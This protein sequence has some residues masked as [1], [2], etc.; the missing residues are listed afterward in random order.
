MPE[1]V[2]TLLYS[3]DSQSSGVKFSRNFFSVRSVTVTVC[4]CVL[5]ALFACTRCDA[6]DDDDAWL[7]GWLHLLG[8]VIGECKAPIT[9]SVMGVSQSRHLSPLLLRAIAC[10]SV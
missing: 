2:D 8:G 6:D 3:E 10:L 1:R 7:L 4:E 9:L 5:I